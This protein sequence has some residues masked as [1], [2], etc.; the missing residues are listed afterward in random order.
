MYNIIMK[1]KLKSSSYIFFSVLLA[2]GISFLISGCTFSGFRS[3]S[4]LSLKRTLASTEAMSINRTL[5]AESAKDSVTLKGTCITSSELKVQVQGALAMPLPCTQGTFLI[6]VPLTGSD[7]A[8]VIVFSQL[9]ATGRL[10]Q[11]SVT[12][13]KDTIAPVITILNIAKMASSITINGTC[14]GTTPIVLSGDISSTAAIGCKNNIFQA[15]GTPSMGDGLKNIEVSQTDVAGNKSILRQNFNFDTKAPIVTITSPAFNSQFENT[16]QLRGTCE[17][18][19]DVIASGTGIAEKVSAPCINGA[20][21]MSANLSLNLGNKEVIVSQ[22]DEGGNR[23]DA[24]VTVRRIEATGNAPVIAILQPAAGLVTK[25]GIT[26]S[27]TCTVGLTVNFSGAVAANSTT[28]CAN[29]TFSAA[30]NFSANDGNKTVT[31]SQTNAQNVMGSASRNFIRDAT[32][33]IVT[34]ANPMANSSFGAVAVTVS[35]A[36]ESGLTVAL[37]GVGIVTTA[38][39]NCV[40]G[41]YSGLVNLTAGDGAKEIR[42]GQTDAAQNFAVATVTVTRDEVAPLVSISEPLAGTVATNGVYLRGSC[43]SG[44]PVSVTGSGVASLAQAQC[45]ASTFA[46][47]IIFSAMDGA[48]EVLVSQVDGA[49]NRGS[50]TRSFQKAAMPVLDGAMLYAQ[51]CAGCHSALADS[52]KLDRTA[53]QI[54]SAR[55]NVQLMSSS[56]GLAM[57]STAQMDAIALALKTVPVDTQANPFLCQSTVQPAAH[58]L[59]RLAKSEYVNTIRDLF[60]GV[61]TIPELT[62]EIS[63]FPEELNSDNPFDR[64]ADSLNL[65]LIQAHNRISSKIASLITSSTTKTNQIFTETCFAGLTVTD[66]CIVSFIDRFGTKAYRRPVKPEEK[67]PLIAA[68]KIG[69]NKIESTGFLLRAILMSPNFLYHLEYEGIPTDSTISSLKLS[70]YELA[71]RISYLIVN[72]APDSELAATAANGTILNDATLDIQLKRLM[73]LPAAK[74]SFRR[75][76]SSWFTLDHMRDPSYTAAFKAGIDTTNLNA[77][78]L[79]ESLLFSDHV[80][81]EGKKL[82]GLLTDNTAFIKSQSLA[83]IYGITM[84]N[85]ADGRV[86]LNGGQYAGLLTR[87]AR[88]MSG[89]DGTSPILRGVAIKRALLCDTLGSPDPNSLPAG[90]L[91]PPPDDPFLSTR[92]RYENKTSSTTCMACHSQINPFGFALERYDALGR[93]R[94]IEKVLGPAGNLVAEHPV[95]ANVTINLSAPP[96]PIVNGGIELSSTIANSQKFPMCFAKRWFQF[97]IRRSSSAL[98][99]CAL[100][101]T[102]ESLKNPNATLL[103]TIKMTIVNPEFKMRRMK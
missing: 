13:T 66:A 4:S 46:I 35:G 78:A 47:D 45:N 52:T 23:G 75:F 6:T 71:S 15:V 98:D 25:T 7:G 11:D 53:S 17:S 73:A 44:L 22:T 51:H 82:A 81:F 1:S 102:Y 96:D 57:L 69:A 60:V 34:I 10:L 99:N 14:E 31:A 12:I 84:P 64:G 48:K 95:D 42:V 103:D 56:Q 27:G 20:F 28:T 79:E 33:P 83:Q 32:N 37:Y 92:K 19:F 87:A 68:Y 3:S 86:T 100:A 65:G 8:K 49:G 93:H 67:P 30:I 72:S 50:N 70:S 63:F 88:T 89:T 54:I 21:T 39:A 9:D 26:L 40:N 85:T 101:S 76:F 58:R 74:A 59:Q 41:I 5:I 2:T 16:F 97:S 38:S 24:F 90:S 43:E 61:V 62:V 91:N 80:V 77:D 55:T 94:T 29:G 36:C 18:V